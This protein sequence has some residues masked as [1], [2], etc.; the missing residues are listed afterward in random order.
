MAMPR[1]KTK[2]MCTIGPAS[3]LRE[4]MEVI[5]LRGNRLAGRGAE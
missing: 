3:E 2:M 1:H 4:V 5:D